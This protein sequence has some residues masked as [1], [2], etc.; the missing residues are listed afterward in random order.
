MTRTLPD[1]PCARF[2]HRVDLP[3][4]HT[5]LHVESSGQGRAVLFVH[6]LLGDGRVFDRQFDTLARDHLALAV[7]LRGHGRSAAQTRPQ[8][9]PPTHEPR[10]HAT[11][12]REPPHLRELAHDLT[13]ILD[14]LGLPR[15]VLV[16]HALGGMVALRS[17]LEHPERVAGLVLI[18]T[19]HRSEEPLRRLELLALARLFRHTQPHPLVAHEL[20]RRSFSRSFRRRHP[21]LVARWRKRALRVDRHEIAHTLHAIAH[22]H[23]LSPRLPTLH[24][25]TLIVAGRQDRVVPAAITRDLAG[26]LPDCHLERLPA[27][28]HAPPLEAPGRV[29]TLVRAFCESIRW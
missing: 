18:A 19:N 3:H 5:T 14:Q 8:V 10:R 29:A 1:S 24:T 9:A 4:A 7:D 17:A 21:D 11:R 2:V 22:R 20:A 28:G 15:A 12:R 23:D 6:G 13:E 26:L 27:V 16:G 25:P